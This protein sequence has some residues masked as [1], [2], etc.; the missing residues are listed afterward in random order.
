MIP[1]LSVIPVPKAQKKGP[2]VSFVLRAGLLTLTPLCLTSEQA[3]PMFCVPLS[4]SKT[5]SCSGNVCSPRLP[6]I[7]E[8]PGYPKL[9]TDGSTSWLWEWSAVAVPRVGFPAWLELPHL[10]CSPIPISLPCMV[11]IGKLLSVPL[12]TV[13]PAVGTT[14]LSFSWVLP[15]APAHSAQW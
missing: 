15:E 4:S 2:C 9:I 1:A 6:F 3:G 11:I 13:V 10:H 7:P 12:K 8:V 14:H 5:Q